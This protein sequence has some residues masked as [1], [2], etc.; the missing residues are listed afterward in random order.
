MKRGKNIFWGLLFI[1]GAIFIIVN[2]LG[3]FQD[4]NV[5]TVVFTIILAGVLIDSILRRSFGGILFSLAF[6]CILYDKTLGIETLTPWPVLVAALC[7]TIG[8]N[9]IFKEKKRSWNSEKM[10]RG[11]DKEKYKEVID[12]E[13]DEWVRCEVSFSS[14]TKYINSTSFRK[15]DL[16]CSFGNMNVYFDN[17]ILGGGSALVNVEVSFGDM[18]LYIPKTWK[19]VM[20]LDNSFGGCKEYGSCA[21]NSEEN[22]LMLSGEVSFGALEIYY[23]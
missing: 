15:A 8:L 19:V 9:M 20:N 12:E 5:L 2:K 16:E 3:Y 7:G 4:I 17:A 11:W 10:H 1:L 18:K 6:L 22:V 13:S 14:T 21:A 23:I